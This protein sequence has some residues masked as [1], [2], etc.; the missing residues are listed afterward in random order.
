M[1]LHSDALKEAAR[2]RD[3]IEEYNRQY[4]TGDSS[5][6][7]DR[8]YDALMNRLRSLEDE[9]P[10]LRTPDSPTQ[11]VGSP[12]LSVFETVIHDP[13]MLSLSNVFTEE[14]FMAFHTR[15]AGELGTHRI[16]YSV[17]PKLDGVSLALVYENSVL[18]R[19]GTRGDGTAGENVTANARTIR[20]VPLRLNSAE[21]VSVEVRGEVY[22]TL[23]DFNEMNQGREQPFKNPRNAASG[24]LRQL[25]SSITAQRPLSFMAYAAGSDPEG[26]HSQKELFEKL[27]LWGFHVSPEN[28]FVDSPRAVVEAYHRLEEKRHELPME[29]DGVVVKV[30]DF[31]A[32]ERLGFVSRAPRWATAW[33]FHAQ[34]VATTLVR[35]DV[36]VGR[37][38]RLTPT[39]RLEPVRVG[40]VTVTNATLHNQDEVRRKDVRPGDTVVVR[41]AGDVIPEVVGSLPAPGDRG[42]PFAMPGE[43]PVCGGPVTAAEGEVNLYCM[44]PSCPARLKRS[45]EHWASRRAMD[46]EGLGEKLCAQLVDEGLVQSIADLYD[47]EKDTL[48]VL[49]R[50]GELSAA[51]LLKQLEESRK[52][53]LSRFLTGLGIPGV[54]EVASRDIAA[55]FPNLERLKGA[56]EEELSGIKGIGP[57]TASSLVSFFSSEV[58][59]RVVEELQ[60][61][62]FDPEEQ[63][64]EKGSS[65]AGETIVF[66]GTLS[67]PRPEAKRMAEGAGAKVTGTVTGKTTMVVAGENAGSKLDR[68]R[69]LG[70]RILTEDEFLAELLR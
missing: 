59:G 27:T 53:P 25:D 11:R 14:D 42:E 16:E 66:T 2:L 57:V 46:I 62:G 31:A 70:I 49:E 69:E 10:A 45:L 20:S 12:P 19:A 4:Y 40:G 44:N 21:P 33:K 65:L 3:L 37:T 30:S 1:T 54:G 55:A 52:K 63:V 50:M 47:L 58:T 8:E 22:F 15:I 23:K 34:E 26:V 43:C 28:R 36:G 18:V 56:G 60:S 67:I 9:H 13:P 24:S 68:A 29:T 41:R 51:N 39:A 38:G 32:R 5:G 61:K 6:I 64:Q 7:S 35:I 17:E 48:A